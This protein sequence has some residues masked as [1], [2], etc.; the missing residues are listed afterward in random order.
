MQNEESVSILLSCDFEATFK[1][2]QNR[3][4]TTSIRF[5]TRKSLHKQTRKKLNQHKSLF[6]LSL[7]QMN[8]IE[9][10]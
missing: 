8:P 6:S 2:T 1:A 4:T 9:Q 10:N 5:S 3:N 7:A